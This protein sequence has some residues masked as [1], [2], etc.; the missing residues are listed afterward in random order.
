MGRVFRVKSLSR[1]FLYWYD[2]ASVDVDHGKDYDYLYKL[3]Y[4]MSE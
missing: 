1:Q 3:A 2:M 4:F